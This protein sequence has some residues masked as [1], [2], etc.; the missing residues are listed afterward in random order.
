MNQLGD[1]K[2]QK[3]RLEALKKEAEEERERAREAARERI[4]LDFEKGQ[5]GLAASTGISTSGSAN[6]SVGASS[7]SGERMSLPSAILIICIR[8]LAKFAPCKL[9]EQNASS[10]STHLRFSPSLW[11]QKKRHSNTLKRSKPRRS[12]I[13]SPTSGYLL[14]HPRIHHLVHRHH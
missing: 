11:K 3:V 4:L 1:I 9:A 14:S 6:P 8:H 7:D 2:R 5:L 13:S 10:I 12:S